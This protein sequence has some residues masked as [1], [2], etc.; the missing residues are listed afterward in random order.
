VIKQRGETACEI[1]EKFCKRDSCNR[2]LFSIGV[3]NCGDGD[4]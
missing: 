4:S 1:L 3:M 2:A